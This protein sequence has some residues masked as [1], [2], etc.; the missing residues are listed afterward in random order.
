V[1]GS[2]HTEMVYP[3]A[4]GHPPQNYDDREERAIRLSQAAK[5]SPSSMFVGTVRLF[6]LQGGVELHKTFSTDDL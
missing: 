2:L 5:R 6:Y 1:S 3:P 4:D